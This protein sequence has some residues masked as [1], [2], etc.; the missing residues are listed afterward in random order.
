M[1]A[2]A[3]CQLCA[4]AESARQ[5]RA[6]GP[7]GPICASCIEA[8]LHAV[9]SGADEGAADDALPVRLGRH[10]T[11]ACES[12]ERSSRDSFLGFRRRSL[13]RVTFPRSGTV[14]CAECLDSSGDLINRAVRG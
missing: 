8:G 1:D 6:P 12:C 11:T 3:L 14:L 5:H 10:D 7:S 2:P 4:R 9:S 13:A